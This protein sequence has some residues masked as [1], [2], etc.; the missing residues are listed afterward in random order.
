MST[1]R[2]NI[3]VVNISIGNSNEVWHRN[4]N[5]QLPLAAL[6]DELAGAVPLYLKIKIIH[7]NAK[8]F[9]NYITLL[10]EC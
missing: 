2:Y 1:V 9:Q 6:I 4:Y 8:S 5:R 7:K 3:K 10:H